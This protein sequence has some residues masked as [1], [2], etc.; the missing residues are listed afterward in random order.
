MEEWTIYDWA[1]FYVSHGLSVIPLRPGG[2]ADAKAPA[3]GAWEP[4]KSRVATDDELRAWFYG[5]T[6][7]Q[8]GIA[9]VAGPSNLRAIDIDDARLWPFFF[10]DPPDQTASKT[11]VNKTKHGYHVLFIVKGNFENVELKGWAELKAFAKYVVAPPSIHPE[12]APYEWLK[13]ARLVKIA[14]LE[15][16]DLQKSIMQK[17]RFLSTY[18]KAIEAVIPVYNEGSRHEAALFLSGALRKQK[19]SLEDAK[20]FMRLLCLLTG[21]PEENDRM[22]AVNDTY[23]AD[24]GEIAG[25]SKVK[26][27]LEND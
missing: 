4:Y 24:I 20:W 3:I 10:M 5:K 26:A 13:D 17:I 9:L 27:M 6:P 19:V 11:W 12:G 21:D 25:F 1:K 2:T 8:V 16:G 18:A 15:A 7:Q 22:R 23:E 14:E